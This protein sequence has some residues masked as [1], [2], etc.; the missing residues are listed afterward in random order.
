LPIKTPPGSAWRNKLLGFVLMLIGSVAFLCMAAHESLGF[1][2]IANGIAGALSMCV[3]AGVRY[4]NRGRKFQTI[5]AKE[6]VLKDSR[7]PVVYL[8]SFNDDAATASAHD[9]DL[10]PFDVTTEEEQ[11][12]AALN[13]IGP[14]LAIGR[15]GEEL[16]ELGAARFYVRDDEWQAKV[17]DLIANAQLVVL[18]SGETEGLMWE[19]ETAVQMLKLRPERLLLLVPQ[20]QK[21]YELF[22]KRAL[23]CLPHELPEWPKK[24]GR[25]RD[26][27][28]MIYFKPDW[29]PVFLEIKIPLIG[30]G[31]RVLEGALKMTLRPVFEQLH[32]VW[33]S[34]S[35]PWL[36]LAVIVF[37][38]LL[39]FSLFVL[40]IIFYVNHAG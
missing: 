27:R 6:L 23:P 22:R 13:E 15:P 2:V 7:P 26:L 34:P 39:L 38:V 35:S 29:T 17:K 25:A 28:G 5:T 21:S 12:V 18:R 8:R 30:R 20:N 33:T 9:A 32:L 24:N 3:P 10:L 4:F 40:G 14:V 37:G 31:K 19:V 36:R 11:L 16:P 1:G